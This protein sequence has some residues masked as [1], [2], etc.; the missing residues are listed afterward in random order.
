MSITIDKSLG[1]VL[2]HKHS[3]YLSE[4]AD[5]VYTTDKPSIALKSE[6]PTKVSEL[7]NDEGFIAEEADPVYTADKPSI[8]LKEEL[9]DVLRYNFFVGS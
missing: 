3:Q 4:E 1:K 2:S 6:L 5:P 8:A 7:E 9:E